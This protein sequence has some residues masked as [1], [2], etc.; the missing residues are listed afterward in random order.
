MIVLHAIVDKLLAEACR[1]FIAAV[2]FVTDWAIAVIP[3]DFVP[4]QVHAYKQIVF[5]DWFRVICPSQI[6]LACHR[7]LPRVF[8]AETSSH[9]KWIDFTRS[10]SFMYD[11][12]GHAGALV[13]RG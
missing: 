5:F 4:D 2:T 13:R 9:Q 3:I 7:A 10:R 1:S 6:G 12:S 8:R 11:F